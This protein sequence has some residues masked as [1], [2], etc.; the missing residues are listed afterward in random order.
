VK[1][2]KNKISSPFSS[3]V[4]DSVSSQ[5]AVLDK[6]GMIVAVNKAWTEFGKKNSVRRGQLPARTSV[7]TNYLEILKESNGKNAHEATPAYRGIAKVI[8]GKLKRFALEYP[9]H[10]KIEERWFMMFAHRLQSKRKGVVITHT[11]ITQRKKM[12]QQ[13]LLHAQELER[14]VQERTIDLLFK[15]NE[16]RSLAELK[17]KFITTVSHEFRTPMT[18]ISLAVGIIKKYKN[19]LPPAE[20]DE[21]LDGINTQIKH[22]SYLLEDIELIGLEKPDRTT[23]TIKRFHVKTF[24]D[25]LVQDVKD[26]FAG[27]EVNLKLSPSQEWMVTDKRLLNNILSNLLS[28]AIK[29]S[30]DKKIVELSVSSDGSNFH[31]KVRDW[32]VGIPK[33]DQHKIFDTFYRG[34]NSEFIRG[35]GLGLSIAKTTVELLGGNISFESEPGEVTTFTIVLPILTALT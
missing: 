25:A 5:I 29:F 20:M 27:Y 2:R 21:K 10:S 24:I 14:K 1:K 6:T 22:L 26:R 4:F 8:A 11:E 35:I 3:D 34:T 13:H 23:L 15:L 33:V 31:F 19:K 30:P 32:G 17:S 18:S 16:E 28:N 7:G 9:C 12:E